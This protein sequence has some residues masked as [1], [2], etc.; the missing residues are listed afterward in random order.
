M[1][2]PFSNQSSPKDDILT[3]KHLEILQQTK[4]EIKFASS[5]YNLAK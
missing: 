2:L 4:N 3:E 1:I 5:N